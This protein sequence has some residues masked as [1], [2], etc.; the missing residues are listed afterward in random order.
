[1]TW[2]IVPVILGV[3]LLSG[4]ALPRT[5]PVPEPKPGAETTAPAPAP[6][7]P[8]VPEPAPQ[9][10]PGADAEPAPVPH[11]AEP[12]VPPVPNAAD[13]PPP[14]PK[15]TEPPAPKTDGTAPQAPKAD[16][17]R[18]DA[19]KPTEAAPTAPSAEPPP[20]ADTGEPPKPAAPLEP[21]PEPP[22][23]PVEAESEADAALCQRALTE[24]GAEFTPI[25]RI[26]DGD[27]CGIDKP[28]RIKTLMTGVQIAPE[29]TV[30]CETALQLA[31]WVQS[32]VIPAAGVALAD[33]GKLT[34]VDQASGYV[35]RK[36]NNASVGKISEHARGNGIDLAGLTFE[37]GSVPMKIVTQEDSTLEGAYQ[38]SLN[39]TACLYF[40]TVLS[41]GSD[42]AHQDHMHLDVIGRKGGYRLCQ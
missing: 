26:D 6:Q 40:T 29:A 21:A 15:G 8:P 10:A 5:G 19:D 16:D 3:I 9:K 1:M 35:C 4:A 25:S 37:K 22:P 42:A 27:G 36:R 14:V 7:A 24:L 41:P 30:R 34:T 23:P 12:A 13:T 2:K 17:S 11:A 31:R 18:P 33:K 20:K 38:R 32:A 28:I 39:A